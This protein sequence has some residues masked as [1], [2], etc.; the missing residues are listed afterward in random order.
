LSGAPGGLKAKGLLLLLIKNIFGKK[1]SYPRNQLEEWLQGLDIEAAAVGDVSSD[2]FPVR[3][4]VKSW[5]V[6]HYDFL[7]L[8]EYDLNKP[9]ALKEIYDIVF[10]LEVFEYVF[11][12]MQA[13]Q[14][15]HG[16]L[17]P[18]GRLYA[19]FHFVYPHHSTRF[20]DYLRFT[21]W[22]VARLLEA[23]GFRTWEILPR[24]L[25]TPA[26]ILQVYAD[27]SMRGNESNRG[28]LHHEQGYLVTADK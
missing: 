21:R 27:E 13:M 3:D 10:C 17:K 24:Y 6:Q 12:P 16:I 22:G 15:L 25:K 7:N 2:Q 20:K 8:P 4:R 23:A 5:Q 28:P 19:S 11:D 18:A 1:R 9:W 26:L 14:N